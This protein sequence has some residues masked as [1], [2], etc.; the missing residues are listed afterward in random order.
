MFVDQQKKRA[1]FR[2][3]LDSAIAEL[4]PDKEIHV[5]LDNYGTHKRNHDWLTQYGGRVP[6]HF[7]P[8]LASWLNQI[9][10]WFAVLARRHC[11]A[12]VCGH[13]SGSRNLGG[14][15]TI[16]NPVLREL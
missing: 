15:P 5:I 7:T 6:F 3:F 2:R 13:F 4:P 12:R 1:D 16:G 11:A 8:T 10:I 14:P 9:E